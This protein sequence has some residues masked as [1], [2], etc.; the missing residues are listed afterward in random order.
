MQG[1]H[2]RTNPLGRGRPVEPNR[3][4]R[5]QID[6]RRPTLHQRASG[7]ELELLKQGSY[8][9]RL[10]S[11]SGTSPRVLLVKP[12]M[13]SPRW[14][15]VLAGKPLQSQS[16]GAVTG[17]HGGNLFSGLARASVGVIFHPPI[18]PSPAP[19]HRSHPLY[20]LSRTGGG[21]QVFARQRPHR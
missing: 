21:G 14:Y 7:R 17:N 2:H 5:R 3:Y 4:S 18:L 6:F 1:L 19:V 12:V 20:R 15:S 16:A 8:P 9:R 11:P 10:R 13:Q